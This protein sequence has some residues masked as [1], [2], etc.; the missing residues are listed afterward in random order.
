MSYD[1]NRTRWNRMLKRNRRRVSRLYQS[2]HNK[3]SF[4]KA[5]KT[6]RLVRYII[7]AGAFQKSNLRGRNRKYENPNRMRV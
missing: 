1:V 3:Q 7:G 4:T 2:G 5:E 6:K